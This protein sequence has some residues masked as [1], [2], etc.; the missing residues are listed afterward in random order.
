[1]TF[2]REMTD[3]LMV[4]FTDCRNRGLFNSTKRKDFGPVWSDVVER[5]REVWP[6]YGWSD[7]VISTKYDT[8]RKRFQAW[9]T[10][11]DGYPD[12][13]LDPDTG[14]PIVP[15]AT[16][17]QFVQRNKPW[18]K[19]NWLK[20]TPLGD[21]GVYRNL[22]RRQRA[23]GNHVADVGNVNDT[24]F[25]AS[26]VLSEETDTGQPPTRQSSFS[27]DIP[28]QQIASHRD[29]SNNNNE[30]RDGAVLARLPQTAASTHAA[31]RLPGSDD[32]EAAVEDLQ[33]LFTGRVTD[34]ELLNC[35]EHLQ[36]DPMRA[37]MWNKLG[38]SMK[39]LYVQRWKG[40]WR[41]I[42]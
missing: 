14:L 24:Q 30:A 15:A 12:V 23:S 13:T 1:M 9:K 16:W 19:L 4:W 21:V 42:T 35:L 2:T 25:E 40:G 7:K 36:K 37:V 11:V 18:G 27:V 33:Q 28:I 38:V 10:L 6:R 8:E 17:E 29:A 39:R 5:S 3:Q 41:T 31:P 34:K 32:L 20:T 22:F 26:S